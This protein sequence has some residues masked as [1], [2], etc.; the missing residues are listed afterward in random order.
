MFNSVDMRKCVV[1]NVR[2]CVATCGSTTILGTDTLLVHIT[3]DLHYMFDRSAGAQQ[4]FNVEGVD[5]PSL[6]RIMHV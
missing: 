5:N 1:W 6:F 4:E 3:V 2:V